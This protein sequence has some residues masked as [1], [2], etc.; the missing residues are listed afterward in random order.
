MNQV[1]FGLALLVTFVPAC[2]TGQGVEPSAGVGRLRIEVACSRDTDCPASFECESETEHGATVTFCQSHDEAKPDGSG[3]QC[4]AGYEV[5]VEHGTSF[6]KPHGG[7]DSGRGGA[8]RDRADHGGHGGESGDDHGGRGGESGDD[9]GGHGGESGDDHGGHGGESGD[10]HGGHGAE[11]G[12][13]HGGHGAEPGDDHS[14]KGK[15]K[16]KDDAAP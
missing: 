10:D 12:D 14:G 6:C 13:D 9:H 5:E 3:A 1:F 8:G 11:P 7:D 15:G 2:G 16:G 4:P